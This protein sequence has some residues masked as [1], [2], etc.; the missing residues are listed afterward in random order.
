LQKAVAFGLGLPASYY[1]GLANDLAA[2]RD[3]LAKGLADIGFPT[4]QADGS[5]FLI[6]DIGQLGLGSDVEAAQRMTVEAALRRYQCRLSI[7]ARPPLIFCGF[8]FASAMRFS[9]KP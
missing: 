7:R 1:S 8:V 6:A 5:Y 2:K 3:R 4:L 9:M